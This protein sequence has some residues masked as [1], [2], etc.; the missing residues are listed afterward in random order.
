M[1][2]VEEDDRSVMLD[3]SWLEKHFAD[4]EMCASDVVRNTMGNAV[5]GYRVIIDIKTG[6]AVVDD[7]SKKR[8]RELYD[9]LCK[10]YEKLG[11]TKPTIGYFQVISGDYEQDHEE[12][13]PEE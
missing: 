11:C 5:Y 1:F 10:H 9:I 2:G 8:V 13:V 12:Y 3:P 4:M 7:D 6:Q